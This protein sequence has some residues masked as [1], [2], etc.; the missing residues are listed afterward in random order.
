MEKTWDLP[1]RARGVSVHARGLR[2]RG[3]PVHLTLTMDGVWPSARGDGVGTPDSDGFRGSMP[4]LHVP[5]LTLRNQPYG[6][7]HI[8]RGRH[9]SLLLCR[10]TLSFATPRRF[11]R[12]YPL[13]RQACY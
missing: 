1:L 2:P 10:T 9:G 4:G 12:R 7:P 13:G 6:G 5:L 3:V 8:A 11:S